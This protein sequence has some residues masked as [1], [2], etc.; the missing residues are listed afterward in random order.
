[1][2]KM[3]HG[4]SMIVAKV[5]HIVETQIVITDV[6][7][8][9]VNVTTKSKLTEEQVFKDRKPTK[10]NNVTDLEKEERLKQSMVETFQQFQKTQT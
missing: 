1:M 7:V 10:A 5:Q 8:V 9:D 4:K 2:Q 3:F 6:N